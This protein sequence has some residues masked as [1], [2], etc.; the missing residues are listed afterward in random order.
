MV[1][2][3]IYQLKKKLVFAMAS[4]LVLSLGALAIF[5]NLFT[6]SI[7]KS[8]LGKEE[9]PFVMSS[10]RLNIEKEIAMAINGSMQIAENQYIIDWLKQGENKAGIDAIQSYLQRINDV[11]NSGETFVGSW[12]TK[13]YFTQNG[14]VK[15]MSSSVP[16]D[17]WFFSFFNSKALYDTGIGPNKDTGELTLFYQLFSKRFQQCARCCRY[18]SWNWSTCNVY[19]QL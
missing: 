16:T 4:A 15:T 19:Q 1:F 7:I 10:I 12:K 5:N 9:L 18:G 17:G 14:F 3:P 8:R 13:D 2:G 6:S 11:N